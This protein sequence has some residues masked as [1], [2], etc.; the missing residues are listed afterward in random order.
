MLLTSCCRFAFSTPGQSDVENEVH[1]LADNMKSLR[2]KC[3]PSPVCPPPSDRAAR[4]VILYDQFLHG[5]AETRTFMLRIYC[6]ILKQS[7]S[8]YTHAF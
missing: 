1:E 6:V 7:L 8:V 5:I 2:S 4:S 3:T